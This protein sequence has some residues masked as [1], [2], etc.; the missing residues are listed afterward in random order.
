VV[1]GGDREVARPLETTK[2][3]PAPLVTDP[4]VDECRLDRSMP[5]VIARKVEA[6]ARV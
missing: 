3:T 5:E 2:G 4:G 1:L 6:F